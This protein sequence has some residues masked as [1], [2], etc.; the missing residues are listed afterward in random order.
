MA[1][2]AP[3]RVGGHSRIR[4]GGDA[5]G[6]VAQYRRNHLERHAVGEH[7]GGGGMSG[8]M[9]SSPT[10]LCGLGP[11]VPVPKRVAR[12]CPGPNRSCE[13]YGLVDPNFRAE[14]F[15]GLTRS[16]GAECRQGGL[17]EWD[18]AFASRGLGRPNHESW[19]GD[20]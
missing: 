4:V 18:G 20:P 19:T 7:D 1:E 17:D 3:H 14:S 5:N 2:C 9:H 16:M 15:G 6:R 10:E 11:G 12:V 8:G 13:H